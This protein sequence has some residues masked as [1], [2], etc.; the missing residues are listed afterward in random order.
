MDRTEHT[1][2]QVEILSIAQDIM[3]L[4]SGGRKETPKRI[5]LGMAVHQATRSEDL[6]QLLHAAG[7]SFIYDSVMK[8]DTAIASDVL[9]RYN[10]NQKVVIPLNFTGVNP[11]GYIRFANDNIDIN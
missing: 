1:T 10:G 4:V 3:Y 6:V 2:N 5:G 7:H 11:P 8:A 9:S